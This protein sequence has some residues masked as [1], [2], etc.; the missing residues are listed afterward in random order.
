MHLKTSQK[1]M[2]ESFWTVTFL[3]LSGGFQDAYSYFARGKVFAN[4]Q[5]GNM[6]LMAA[7]LVD[8]DV[9]GFIRYL[10]P[11][12]AFALGIAAASVF[13]I[14]FRHSRFHW[15]QSI[16]LI[17]ILLL[18]LT[19]VISMDLFAN[20]LVSFACALQVQSFRKVHGIPFASTMCIGNLRSLIDNLMIAKATNSRR[21][22]RMA[23]YYCWIIFLF[24]AG[25]ALGKIFAEL[26]GLSSI[27]GSCLLLTGALAIMFFDPTSISRQTVEDMETDEE[28]DH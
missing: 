4:A 16:V 5:T 28:Q 11:V 21:N 3:T 27:W 22:R 7:R 2:S 26:F 8:G 1:Q 25:A 20:C 14:R 24:I 9:G 13:R 19:P 12:V 23:F 6:V 17:E 10:F 18:A 15:R